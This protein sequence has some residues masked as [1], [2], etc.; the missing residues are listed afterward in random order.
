MLTE[1]LSITLP[2]M[3]CSRGLDT[4]PGFAETAVTAVGEDGPRGE[5]TPRP[6]ITIPNWPLSSDPSS[7]GRGPLSN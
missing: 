7:T 5:S 3:S 6:T 4:E 2:P 1:E